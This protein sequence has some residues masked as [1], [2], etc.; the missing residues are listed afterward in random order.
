M[1]RRCGGN[2]F[3]RI[4]PTRFFVA[5]C[6]GLLRM[7]TTHVR[8]FAGPETRPAASLREDMESVFYFILHT[9][10]FVLRLGPLFDPGVHRLVPE[11]RVLGLQDPVAFVWK[12]HHLRRHLLLL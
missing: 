1:F 4:L 2:A 11:L 7:T 5:R 10:A 6:G 12:V 3:I 9:S 8:F